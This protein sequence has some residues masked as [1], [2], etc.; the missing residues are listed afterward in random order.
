[1]P[2]YRVKELSLIGNA[3][4]KAG[5]EVEYDGYPADNLEPLDSEGGAK[6]AEYELVN[7]ARVKKMIEDNGGGRSISDN[8]DMA[9]MVSVAVAG[10][11]AKVFPKGMNKASAFSE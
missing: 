3:L 5:D 10:A 8:Q 7:A 6:Q 11:L 2:K 4:Y 1:M 9:A